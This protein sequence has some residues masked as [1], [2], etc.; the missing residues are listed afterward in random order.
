MDEKSYQNILVYDIF[1]TSLFDAIPLFIR[2]K[3]VDELIRVYDGLDIWHYLPLKN[4]I[5]LTTELD[6]FL[7]KKVAV[8]TFFLIIMQKF[9]SYDSLPPEKML[10]L[11]NVIILIKSVFNKDKNRYYYTCLEECSYQLAEK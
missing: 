9:D 7:V 11:R 4:L 8:N 10:T 5:P 2:F 1:Y 3:K 6:V